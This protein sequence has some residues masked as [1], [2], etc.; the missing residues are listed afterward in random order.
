MVNFFSVVVTADGCVL[1]S[2]KVIEGRSENM[3]MVLSA[4]WRE[5]DQQARSRGLGHSERHLMA[6]HEP[7]PEECTSTTYLGLLIEQ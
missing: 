1:R 3:E 7:I 2:Y 5:R 6:F 4:L